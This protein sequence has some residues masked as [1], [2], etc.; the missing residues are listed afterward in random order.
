MAGEGCRDLSEGVVREPQEL[1]GLPGVH[2]PVDLVR[3]ELRYLEHLPDA[4][5]GDLK[6]LVTHEPARVVGLMIALLGMLAAF[7]LQITEE[8][9]GA[10]VAFVG[11]LQAFSGALVTRGRVSTDQGRKDDLYR[12]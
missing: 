1:G 10:V 8:Q 12:R 7:G 6:H 9:V 4:L 3:V 2:E 5:L 11:A